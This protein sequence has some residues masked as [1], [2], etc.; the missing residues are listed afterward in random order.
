VTLFNGS[1]YSSYFAPAASSESVV[2]NLP[3]WTLDIDSD[4]MGTFHTVGIASG[5]TST[6]SGIEDVG[7][8]TVT[9]PVITDPSLVDTGL[10]PVEAVRDSSVEDESSGVTTDPSADDSAPSAV[11]ARVFV[12]LTSIGAL[13]VVV[14]VLVISVRLRHYYGVRPVLSS[15]RRHRTLMESGAASTRFQTS[16]IGNPVEVTSSSCARRSLPVVAAKGH[17][18]EGVPS[19]SFDSDGASVQVPGGRHGHVDVLAMNVSVIDGPYSLQP[20]APSRRSGSIRT[21]NGRSAVPGSA[22]GDS[23]LLVGKH[24]RLSADAA[25]TLNLDCS[26]GSRT[27]QHQSGSDERRGS[28]LGRPGRGSDNCRAAGSSRTSKKVNGV[29]KTRRA[30]STRTT[31]GAAE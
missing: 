12:A 5:G 30:R 7:V 24:S 3:G 10:L 31:S 17:R 27:L 28:R 19:A 2:L 22:P 1:D 25:V 18:V 23:L 21:T 14:A 8:D 13:V 9:D 6:T 29:H 11:S 20:G 26:A 4:D 15:S 16:V